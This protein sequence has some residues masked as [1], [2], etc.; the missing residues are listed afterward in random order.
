MG[1]RNGRRAF[2]AELVLNISDHRDRRRYVWLWRH[3]RN[4]G[5]D[6]QGVVHHFPGYLRGVA[7]FWAQGPPRLIQ[8]LAIS[9]GKARAGFVRTR[10]SRLATSAEAPHPGKIANRKLKAGF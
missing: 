8:R 5:L 10:P 2:H 6:G 7:D 4:G 9:E 1:D 3:R